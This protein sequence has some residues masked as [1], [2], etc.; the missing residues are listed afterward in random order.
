MAYVTTGSSDHL[1]MRFV[2]VKKLSTGFVVYRLRST[3]SPLEG[4]HFH[5]R[6]TR[7]AFAG[8]GQ[9]TYDMALDDLII[10]VQEAK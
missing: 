3:T 4:Y 6:T 7:G 2:R 5:L 10:A 1:S 9:E 8:C